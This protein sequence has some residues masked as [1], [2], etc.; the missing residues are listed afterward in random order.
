MGRPNKFQIMR[1]FKEEIEIALNEANHPI[2]TNEDMLGILE[3]H[4]SEWKLPSSATLEDFLYFLEQHGKIK[5]ITLDFPKKKMVRYTQN[6]ADLSL[7]ELAC[8][9][10]KTAYLSHYTAAFYHDLTDNIVKTIYVNQEQSVKASQPWTLTQE[11]ID[12]AFA[13]PMRE[14][15]N[16]AV[17]D[18]QKIVL[19]NGK[20]T[21]NLGVQQEEH[22]RFSNIERT[23]IDI[24][25]RPEYAGGA[26][27]V[28]EIYKRAKGEASVNK[29]YSYLKK[30]EHAYPYHQS[31]G[32][33]LERA[34]YKE[35]TVRL[36]EKFPINLDFHLAYQIQDSHYSER[37][38]LHYPASMDS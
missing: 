10:G 24:A 32:F 29:L 20:N 23:L 34:G 14:S 12:Q 5:G 17:H 27:E 1:L 36:M 9:L 33:Y 19:L 6:P 3:A 30:L 21:G 8:S 25:V 18:D 16:V 26:F 35:S 37:W 2:L 31:I 38:K 28:L 22:I 11:A 4:R 13:R 15:N 7:L